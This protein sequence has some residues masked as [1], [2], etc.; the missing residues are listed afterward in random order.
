[1][2]IPLVLALIGLLTDQPMAFAR[3]VSAEGPTQAFAEAQ[4]H[5]LI[6][7]GIDEIEIRCKNIDVGLSTRWRC[8]AR[9]S[10]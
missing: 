6:P 2:F 8:R 4:L 5:R 9:W 3:S 1:M 10:S 7:D